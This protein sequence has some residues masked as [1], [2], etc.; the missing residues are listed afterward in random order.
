MKFKSILFPDLVISDAIFLLALKK[1]DADFRT[2][3]EKIVLWLVVYLC[4]SALCRWSEIIG[5]LFSGN[6]DYG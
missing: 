2:E 3:V 4:R 1:Q 5:N 6:N